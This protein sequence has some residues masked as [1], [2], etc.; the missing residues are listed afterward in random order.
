MIYEFGDYKVKTKYIKGSFFDFARWQAFLYYKNEWFKTSD[1][2]N[3]E[4]S[5]LISSRYYINQHKIALKNLSN[6]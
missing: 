4:T 1:W 5:A 3:D 2:H 6:V